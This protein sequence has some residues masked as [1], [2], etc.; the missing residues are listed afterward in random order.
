MLTEVGCRCRVTRLWESVDPSID[1]IV[2]LD[3]S[4][5]TYFTSFWVSPFSFRAGNMPMALLLERGGSSILFIDNLLHEF[6]DGIHVSE[7]VEVPWY[8][9]R[10]SAPAR[11]S[12]L[13][14]AILARLT[15]DG[16][17]R[18]GVETARFPVALAQI[19]GN[20]YDDV[21]P[22][23][24][25]LRARKEPDE[26]ALLERCVGIGEALH[27]LAWDE[28]RP[29]S[30]ELELWAALTHR[31]IDLAGCPVL[32]YGDLLTGERT[33]LIGGGPTRRVLTSG[34]LVLLD[35][36]VVLHGYRADFANT[37]VCG[38]TPAPR[39]QEWAAACLEALLAA[40]RM[41]GPGVACRAVDDVVRSRLDCWKPE[42]D[43]P[44][45]TGHGLGLGH[46]EPPFLVPEADEILQSGNVITLE[47]GLYAATQGMR[48]ERDYLITT[49]GHRLLSHHAL[50][51][52]PGL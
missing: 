52:E 16:C 3:P 46:P 50:G 13:L 22:V 23:L 11:E 47:P 9:G 44:H 26:I 25:S 30:T 4:G 40:E 18:L 15:G 36:S 35:V 31:A 43:F 17:R 33:G 48:F 19:S 39:Q 10:R 12:V 20:S 49:E 29:G 5:V 24:R 27:R 34:D 37:F 28:V 8:E 32:V 2:V 38:G 14:D 42:A 41:I 45:H 7:V 1:A 6:T 51:L 21:T